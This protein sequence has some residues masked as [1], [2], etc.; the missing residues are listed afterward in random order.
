MYLMVIQ[1]YIR[2]SSAVEIADHIE[3]AVRSGDV[4]PGE[5]LPT[6]RA[7]AAALGVSPATLAA[8][9]RRLRERGF[10][11]SRGRRGTQI[12]AVL[13]PTGRRSRPLPEGVRDLAS[14]NPDPAL[15]PALG[16]ALRRLAPP[17]RLYGEDLQDPDLIALVR[18]QLHADGVP[19]EHLTVTSGALDGLERALQAHLRAGDRVAVEDPAFSGVL[20]LLQPLGLV[21][22]P[23]EIDDSGMRPAAL[24]RA[25][26]SGASALI[27]TP[28][29][30]NPTGAAFDAERVRALASVLDA[31]P[32]ALVLE[33][34][35]AGPVCGAKAYTLC[36]GRRR[37]AV[38]RSFS[39]ALG[40]D[41]RVA[42][43][44]GDEETISR[45]EGRQ[46]IGMRWVSHVL[47]Q[48]VVALSNEKG[49]R[50]RLRRATATY[51]ERRNALIE[52][53]ARHGIPASGRSGLNVWIPVPEEAAVVAG[54]LNAGYAVSAGE[55]FRLKSGPAIRV[56]TATLPPDEAVGLADA[57]S[58]LLGP[59]SRTLR[60]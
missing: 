49:M 56:T 57:L 18:R 19:S 38:S 42:V 59:T 55:R 11:V 36:P 25:L 21:P 44:S 34:D 15:L 43:L 31:H 12:S 51:A 6:V 9:Y 16:P 1:K 35:H 50:T 54:L 46:L 45:V 7:G 39:K 28:R 23:V 32:D 41:L 10:V 8:A 14:G 4:G 33:D 2:G 26:G 37:F 24:D 48:L 40:P 27:V 5:T 30:Q 29:A 17:R 53:L 60:T 58:D 22:V 47:Q 3:A 20:A 13:A 52:A